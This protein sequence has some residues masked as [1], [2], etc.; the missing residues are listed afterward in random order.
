MI[1]V[2][3]KMLEREVEVLDFSGNL[4]REIVDRLL[5]GMVVALILGE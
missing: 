2:H 4:R 5:E 3:E 1:G